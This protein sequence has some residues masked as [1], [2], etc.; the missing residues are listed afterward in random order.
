VGVQATAPGQIP[1]EK[2]REAWRVLGV[3]S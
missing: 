3:D 2:L 1:I